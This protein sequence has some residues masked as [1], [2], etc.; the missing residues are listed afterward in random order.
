[1]AIRPGHHHARPQGH[2]LDRGDGQALAADL[3]AAEVDV[4]RRAQVGI[5]QPAVVVAVVDA[6]GPLAEVPLHWIGALL[7]GQT[8]DPLVDRGHGNARPLAEAKAVH[9]HRHVDA[10]VREDPVGR[11]DVHRQLSALGV[12]RH[13]DEAQGPVRPGRGDRIARL[14]HRH[15]H[16]GAPAPQVGTFQAQG[17]AGLADGHGLEVDDVVGGHRHLGFPGVGRLQGHLD[18]VA[19]GVAPC[20]GRHPHHVRRLDVLG[21]RAPAGGEAHGRA[22]ALRALQHQAIVAPAQAPVQ[23]RR[24]AG[25]DVYRAPGH[26]LV[27][28]RSPPLPLAVLLEP[29]VVPV[30]GDQ[31][32]GHPLGVDAPA[33][34]VHRDQV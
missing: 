29:V 4:G 6:Q 25:A 33:E 34:G 3:V 16:I 1:M 32:P 15:Q 19:L 22:L 21:R 28:A 13:I 12:Q 9:L 26:H 11:A 5:Q 18:I 23:P 20:P 7:L 8:Q 30:L 2:G 27:A 31:G 10:G 14:D 24:G 17:G